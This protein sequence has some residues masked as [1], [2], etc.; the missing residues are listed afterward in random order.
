MDEDGATSPL[1]AS[2]GRSR[3]KRWKQKDLKIRKY[4]DGS[5]AVIGALIEVH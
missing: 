5:E 4:D 2:G 3:G 1:D